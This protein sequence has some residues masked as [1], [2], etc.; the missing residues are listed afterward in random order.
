MKNS[1]NAQRGYRRRRAGGWLGRA[2]DVHALQRVA[3]CRRAVAAGVL[4]AG[5]RLDPQVAV[6]PGAVVAEHGPGGVDVDAV[7]AVAP[8]D[9][10]P[11]EGLRRAS[12]DLDAL[13]PVAPRE[14]GAHDV[15]PA[16]DDE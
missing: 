7:A 1:A 16:A 6:A 14:V 13:A 8:R 11:H 10:L 5:H 9:V 2:G 12:V 4:H 3:V 15:A